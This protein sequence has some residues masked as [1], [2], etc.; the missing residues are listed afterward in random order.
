MAEKEQK[1]ILIVE[2]DEAINNLL[3][4][5]LGKQGLGLDT[6]AAESGTEAIE[7]VKKYSPDAIL[8]DLMLGGNMDGNDVL[9]LLGADAKLRKI[10]VIIM[11]AYPEILQR[12]GQ[13]L[14][15]IAKPFNI[16]DVEEKVNRAIGNGH[17]HP[18]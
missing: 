5:F 3:Q 12:T 4:D 2:D 7:K 6:Y 10:P 15:V 17:F 16:V 11:S 14:A 8:L 18:I 13:V 1:R 9:L